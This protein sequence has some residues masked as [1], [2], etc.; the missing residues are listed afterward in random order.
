MHIKSIVAATALFLAPFGAHAAPWTLDKSHTHISFTVNH[1][2]FSSTFGTFG[3]YDAEI[4]FDPDNVEASSVKF[5][6]D[7]SSI[8]TFFE[9]RDEHIRSA[10]FLNTGEHAEI[11]FV[12]TGITKTGDDTADVTGDLTILGETQSVT[13]QAKLNN[14]G[15]NP[16]N[17]DVTVAGMDI[18]GEIDRT[19]FGM[20]FGAPAIGAVI[21][22]TVSLEMSPAS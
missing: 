7:A 21:P 6:I 18:T 19:D 2:G 16:F 10:D 3:A 12:S 8:N 5:T 17:P 9:K 20:G 15:P 4:D 11:T 1:L 22:F 14:L 13:F